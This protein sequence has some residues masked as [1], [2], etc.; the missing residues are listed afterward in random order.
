MFAANPSNFLTVFQSRRDHL[1]E[2]LKHSRAQQELISNDDY[3][4]LLVVLGK[5]QLILGSLDEMKSRHAE[6]FARWKTV[7]ENFDTDTRIDCEHVLAETEAVLAE[8][9]QEEESSTQ[10]IVRRRDEAHGE[11]LALSQGSQVNHAY[12]DALA[13]TTHRHLDVNQ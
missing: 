8:L 12:R 4:G 10:R 9:I 1:R 5:K 7:R 11:L 13:P 2:L 3:T 6:M